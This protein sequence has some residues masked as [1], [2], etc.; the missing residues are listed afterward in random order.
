M[1]YIIIII[2]L[3]FSALFSG[4][5]IAYITSD[6]VKAQIEQSEDSATGRL[7][8]TFYS[9]PS[10]FLSTIL[11]GN[12]IA[13]VIFGMGMSKLLEPYLQAQ[14]SD[15]P[16]LM[17]QTL[18][19]TLVLLIF[20]E[21]LPKNLFQIKPNAIM[22]W[23]ARPFSVIYYGLWIITQFTVY[24]SRMFLKYVLRIPYEE[25]TIPQFT[26]V[27]LG[28]YVKRSTDLDNDLV[29]KA[30]ELEEVKVRECM[31]PRTDINAISDEEDI[32]KI[33]DRFIE[34]KHSRLPVFHES[35]DKITGYLHHHDVLKGEKKVYGILS[36]PESMKASEL[37]DRFR[38]EKLNLAL[39]I[40]EFGGTAGI[41]TL[42]DLLEEIFGEIQDEHDEDEE[43][44]HKK[45]SDNVFELAGKL[46]IDFLNETYNL[47]LP[48]GDYETI[49][50]FILDEFGSI[51]EEGANIEIDPYEFDITEME[52]ARIVK[53]IMTI[54][55]K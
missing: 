24:I 29:D 35:I 46:E 22:S 1:I 39:V 45:I 6:K 55:E 20:G 11:V 38:S 21:F 34:T 51:P 4:L 41:V 36:I 17:V 2:S 7:L 53:I 18:L 49:A 25:N 33:K 50:G 42:E 31:V 52:S 3:I 27:D 15:F 47:K 26:K 23:L 28:N 40:D 5:E 16:V 13:L 30:V 48:E 8:K 43:K 14:M 32:V 19:T 12:N 9:D 54:Q 44:D 37:L 10:K